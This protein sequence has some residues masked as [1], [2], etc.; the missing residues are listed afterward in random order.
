MTHLAL[1]LSNYTSSLT[2][3]LWGSMPYCVTNKI[4]QIIVLVAQAFYISIDQHSW[5]FYDYL[6]SDSIVGSLDGRANFYNIKSIKDKFVSHSS[7]WKNSHVLDSS[8][9]IETGHANKQG[10]LNSAG[11]MGAL[12]LKWVESREGGRRLCLGL[13]PMWRWSFYSWGSIHYS[14]GS[15]T[16][17]SFNKNS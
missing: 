12:L 2:Q 8:L 11:I 15:D 17:Q 1:S 13:H 10:S 14:K 5:Q 16:L 4:W 7:K 6:I 9:A 3:P